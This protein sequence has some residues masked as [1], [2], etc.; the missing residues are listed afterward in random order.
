MGQRP[1]WAQASP[2]GPAWGRVPTHLVPLQGCLAGPRRCLHAC[3]CRVLHSACNLRPFAAPRPL[4]PHAPGHARCQGFSRGSSTYRGVTAHPSGRWEARIGRCARIPS[5]AGGAWGTSASAS[6]GTRSGYRAAGTSRPPT[7]GAGGGA[8]STKRGPLG[9]ASTSPMSLCPCDT[10]HSMTVPLCCTAYFCTQ[11]SLAA[12]TSTLGCTQRSATRRARTTQH[13]CASLRSRPRTANILPPPRTRT[14]GQVAG[15]RCAPTR[16]APA[17][18]RAGVPGALGCAPP[19]NCH[20]RARP[21]R[22]ALAPPAHGRTPHTRLLPACQVRLKGLTA[23]TNYSLAD[24][25]Y[26][27]AEHYHVGIVSGL[28]NPGQLQQCGLVSSC[29]PQPEKG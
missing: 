14:L 5:W 4:P 1:W 23:A 13:W 15:P 28:V 7:W 27:L 19:H 20:G 10:G 25:C 22:L 18:G 8:Q 2:R 9:T 16:G 21:N 24:Y 6:S 12:A 3:W 11:A 17:Q 26:N 29:S